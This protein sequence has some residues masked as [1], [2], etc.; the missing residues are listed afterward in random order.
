M[1][2]RLLLLFLITPI[3]ELALLI[4]VGMW[5]GYWETILI[6]AV[7]AVVGS[8]LAKREGLSAWRRFNEKLA[9]GGL[10]G[11]ELVDGLI[12]LVAG[13]LLITPGVLTDVFGFMGLIPLTRKHIRR[14]LYKRLERASQRGTMGVYYGASTFGSETYTHPEREPS[15]APPPSDAQWHGQSRSVPRHEKEVRDPESDN[16]PER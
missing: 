1:F 4:R 16:E 11:R 2:A 5:I 3:V 13:A 8:Y 12:I 14:Y 9:G 15:D 7:T 6:I 10:P